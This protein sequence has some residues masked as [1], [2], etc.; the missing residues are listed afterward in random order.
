ML[1]NLTNEPRVQPCRVRSLKETMNEADQEK[2]EQAVT[3][4]TW[5]AKKLELQL[6]KLGVD[7]SDTS[8]MRHREQRCSCSRI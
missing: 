8:I 3:D 4:E 6:R 7:I 1:E 2:L 5:P